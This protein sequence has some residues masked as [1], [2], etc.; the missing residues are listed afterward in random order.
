MLIVNVVCKTQRHSQGPATCAAGNQAKVVR[1]PASPQRHIAR[2]IT[3]FV[4]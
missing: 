4:P 3:R 1:P 2:N